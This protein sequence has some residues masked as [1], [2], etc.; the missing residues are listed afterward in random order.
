M[1][2]LNALLSHGAYE[3]AKD[4]STVRGQANPD[5]WRQFMAGHPMP[6]PEVPRVYKKFVAEL[7]AAGI[8][9]LRNGPRLQIM[10]MDQKAVEHLT[11]D[12]EL[13]N[14]ETV[15][16]KSEKLEPVPGGLFDMQL[17]GGHNGNR[18]SYIKFDQKLPNPIMEE[19]IRRIF[20]LT[21]KKFRDVMAG[22]EN[23]NGNTGPLAIQTALEELN[24]NRE[25]DQARAE[26]SSGKK[27]HRDK[28][29]RKLKY[30]KAAQKT[31][32]HPKDWLLDR[33]P[34]LP[35][36]F[37]AVSVMNSGNPLVA[38]PNYLYKELLESRDVLRELKDQVDDVG[39]EQLGVYDAFKAVTGLGD[40]TRPEHKEQ[41]IKG[42]LKTVFGSS[43]KYGTVQR[44][45]LGSTVDLVGRATIVPNPNLDMDQ[46]G[47]PEDKAWNLY[48]PFI[49]RRLVRKGMARA[50]A[51]SQ[52][53]DRGKLARTELVEEMKVRPVIA[54]RAPT[55]HRYGV[56]SFWPQLT[57]NNVLEVPPLVVGGFTADFD[58]DAMQFHVPA[59]EAA[60][61]EAVE[62]LMPSQNLLSAGDFKVHYTPSHEFTG[63]LWKATTGRANRPPIRFRNKKEAVAAYRRGDIAADQVVEIDE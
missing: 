47:L 22:K 50:A 17:T 13:Q 63:G 20:G 3:V 37:R 33:A 60:V 5:L 18:W 52:W 43:P 54:N 27:T 11:G 49:V 6:N 9:P 15:N 8:N 31:G 12:R 7:Q 41:K 59:R 53:K 23:F 56:M 34:V 21:E 36:A 35:P 44:K 2:E 42:I 26:I 46:V 55:L 10:A 38:D 40:P 19:P 62:R 14:S 29:I 61:K 57:A 32:I 45:L 30:L 25:I 48:K 51:A 16:W 24:V 28:G 4:A 1:L 58:G 39:E